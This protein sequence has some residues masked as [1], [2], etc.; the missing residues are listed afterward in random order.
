[1]RYFIYAVIAI[2]GIA[3]IAGFFVA[4]SPQE[5]RMQRFDQQR[6]NDLQSLQYNIIYYWQAK[7]KLPVA[8][9][10]LNDS[11]R[12]VIVPKDPENAADYEYVAKG[13]LAFSLCSTFDA[14]NAAM[15]LY[16]PS[17]PMPVS[18]PIKTAPSGYP[19]AQDV[20]SHAAGHVCFD[21]TIDT[22]FYKPLKLAP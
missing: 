12:G 1:M 13:S 17:A 8:L 14:T 5:Q 2:V 6:V 22:D 20:W 7:Q 3:V 16:P 19:A 9:A 18:A 4:G 10:D 11:T 21:R 15:G